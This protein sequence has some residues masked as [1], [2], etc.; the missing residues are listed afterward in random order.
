MKPQQSNRYEAMNEYIIIVAV[1]ALTAL[2]VFGLFGDTIRAKIN[3]MNDPPWDILI[4]PCRD[5]PAGS[6]RGIDLAAVSGDFQKVFQ[7]LN[8][9]G[10]VA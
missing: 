4:V 9:Q 10:G 6:W 2:T 5:E 1:V 7:D 8:Q 3:E